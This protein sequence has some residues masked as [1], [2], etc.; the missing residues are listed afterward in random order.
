MAG[1]SLLLDPEADPANPARL[2]SRFG[3]K[4]RCLGVI[5]VEVSA[6]LQCFHL[7][8]HR[9]C[10]IR[11]VEPEQIGHRAQGLRVECARATDS[12]ERLV[13]SGILQAVYGWAELGPHA[14]DAQRN[15][16]V[17]DEDEWS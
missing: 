17:E 8:G 14:G 3:A 2:E 12:H 1:H 6:H 15:E 9:V 4:D 11:P 7:V 10:P 5:S 13:R 16:E